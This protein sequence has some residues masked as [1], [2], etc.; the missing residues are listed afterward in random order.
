MHFSNLRKQLLRTTMVAAVCS[1]LFTMNILADET[2]A[3]VSGT[4][5]NGL[6]ISGMTV[7]EAKSY[8]EGFYASSYKL[9][10]REKGGRQQIIEG[11]EIGYQASFSEGLQA[12]LDEQNATGRL[13]GPEIDNSHRLSTAASYNAEALEAKI[14]SL[15]CING[16]DITQTANARISGYTEGEPFTIIPEVQGNNVDPAKTAEVIRQAVAAGVSE[17]SLSDSGC[18][19]DVAVKSDDAGLVELCEVMNR[20]REMEITYVFGQQTEVLGGELI[21]SWLNGAENGVIGVDRAQ[22]GAY[23]QM[24]KEKYDTAGRARIFTSATGREVEVTGPYG[25]I[26]NQEPE[27]DALVAMIQTGQSQSREPHYSQ[28]AAGRDEG[29]WGTNYVEVDLTGQHVYVVKDGAVVWDAPCVTG[30]V[31]KGYTTPPGIF[32]VAYKER[33][34]VL[35]GKKLADGTYEYESP[36]SYWMPF[37]GGIGLHDANWRGKFGGTIYQNSG[38][39]GCINLP[40]AK[41]AALYEMVYKGMPVIC[42]N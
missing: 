26:I 29:D 9:T 36:V 2:D 15:N 23:I 17:V 37:N 33:N 27:T 13:S 20:C 25:W 30:N 3:F 42:Y 38:S 24:L 8:M 14:L 28:A 4:K 19:V 10:I 34:R 21:C 16:S 22:A 7:D 41:V 11:P 6:S 32:S 5:V 39:H 31:A 18:Y 12:I 40:P 35:R 1:T